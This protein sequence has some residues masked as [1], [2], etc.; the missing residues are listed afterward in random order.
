MLGIRSRFPL[1]RFLIILLLIST[2]FI[3]SNDQHQPLDE[4]VL[5]KD[6]YKVLGIGRDAS[7]SEVKKAYRNLVKVHHPDKVKEGAD[8]KFHEALFVEIAEAY[9]I[10]SDPSMRNRYDYERA[11]HLEEKNYAQ[12]EEQHYR[13]SRQRQQQYREQQAQYQREYQRFQQEEYLR[14]QRQ[15][16]QQ[17]QQYEQQQQQFMEDIF[18]MFDAASGGTMNNMD[19]SSSSSSSS[20]G[21]FYNPVTSNSMFPAGEVIFPYEPIITS[22]DGSHFAFLDHHCSL[23][24]Y[25]GDVDALIRHI[26]TSESPDLTALAMER[27]F[28]TEGEPSLKGVCFAGLADDGILRVFRGHPDFPDYRPLWSSDPPNRDSP[29][30]GSYFQRFYL[31]LTNQGELA[32]YTLTAGS[33]EAECVW[34]TTSCNKF[35]A[36]LQEVKMQSLQGLRAGL[37]VLIAFIRNLQD[38][39]VSF[40]DAVMEKG[41]IETLE[42]RFNKF[43]SYLENVALKR[44]RRREQRERRKRR[45]G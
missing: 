27:K 33:S 25:R 31:E 10:L 18:R 22:M 30:Y 3:R 28:R 15:Q 24:V 34:S 13:Q 14:Y 38:H 21:H 1:L 29:Y 35:I 11:S 37:K 44:S 2:P 41:I 40:I 7:I 23:G 17:Q 8:R 32:V 43:K 19:S 26:L 45:A 42:D 5:K 9:E 16:Q 36:T 6:L 39:V 4:S 20:G 12:R